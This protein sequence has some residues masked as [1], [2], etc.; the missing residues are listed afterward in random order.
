M[1]SKTKIIFSHLFEGIENEILLEM[2]KLKKM[3]KSLNEYE[4]RMVKLEARQS[5]LVKH[6][7]ELRKQKRKLKKLNKS[8]ENHLVMMFRGIKAAGINKSTAKLLV[9]ELEGRVDKAAD[10]MQRE[11]KIVS[12]D[13]KVT[14]DFEGA[15]R[16]Y[17]KT[18]LYLASLEKLLK[19]KREIL[20]S[21][22]CGF[23]H[24]SVLTDKKEVQEKKKLLMAVEKKIHKLHH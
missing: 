9:K 23:S 5:F 18:K 21:I 12:E 19:E 11:K 6:L 13:K 10:L 24:P 20:K 17:E 1:T 2:R 16:E 8:N 3:E 14:Y 15:T 7:K 4:K 22:K